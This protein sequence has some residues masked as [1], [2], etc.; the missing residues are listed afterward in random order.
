[1]FAI[2][3]MVRTVLFL[4][5]GNYYRS[6]FAEIL[7]NHH[8]QRRGL[9]WRASSRGLRLGWPGNVGPISQEALRALQA[10]SIH[11]PTTERFP[12]ACEAADLAAAGLVIALKESEHRPLLLQQFPQWVDRVEYWHIHDV[13]LA[14]ADQALAEVEMRIESLMQRLAAAAG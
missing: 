2:R 8:S 12:L 9:P 13:D 1:M 5:T 14:S 10:R 3:S 6:R 7:F 4:C 11:C